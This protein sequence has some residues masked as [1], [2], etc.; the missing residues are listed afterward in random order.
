MVYVLNVY[1]GWISLI[2]ICGIFFYK[3]HFFGRGFS[4]LYKRNSVE[5]LVDFLELGYSRN[6]LSYSLGVG[7]L[8]VQMGYDILFALRGL[9]WVSGNW[10]LL[11]ATRRLPHVNP[12]GR[13]VTK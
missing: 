5:F 8:V 2:R 4:P 10:D 3:L 11:K 13:G 6:L 1:Y 12:S 9:E 7:I